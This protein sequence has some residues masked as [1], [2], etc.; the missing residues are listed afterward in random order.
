MGGRKNAIS[1]RGCWRV[2]VRSGRWH[3]RQW[4][5]PNLG[6]FL[7]AGGNWESQVALFEFIF[8]PFFY[9]THA[10]HGFYCTILENP[11]RPANMTGKG[12]FPT[13]LVAQLAAV[14]CTLHS[15][16]NPPSSFI[17]Y[18]TSRLWIYTLLCFYS[19]DSSSSSLALTVS[20]P[21]DSINLT[22]SRSFIPTPFKLFSET[23]SVLY[24]FY[25]HL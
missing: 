15:S 1:L 23:T 5:A 7:A 8:L 25:F 6:R 22:T 2:N 24:F 20:M 21:G 14:P 16:Y 13:L 4:L 18:R 12:K 17:I 19:I 3:C 9:Y 11:E 10:Q